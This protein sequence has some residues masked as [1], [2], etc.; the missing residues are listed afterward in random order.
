M[1][2]IILILIALIILVPMAFTAFWYL[3]ASNIKS[4]VRAQLNGIAVEMDTQGGTVTYSNIRTSG[5]PSSTN[6][7]ISDLSFQAGRQDD[8]VS[9]SVN[10]SGDLV[11]GASLFNKSE[12]NVA[13]PSLIRVETRIS[14]DVDTIELDTV[15]PIAVIH[16][17]DISI[18]NLLHNEATPMD[19]LQAFRSISYSDQGSTS[20]SQSS[21]GVIT[22]YSQNGSRI[23][24][25]INELDAMKTFDVVIEALGS[26]FET[27]MPQGAETTL[28]ENQK[29]F[30][31]LYSKLGSLDVTVDLNGSISKQSGASEKREFQLNIN[32]ISFNSDLFTA[33]VEGNLQKTLDDFLPHGRLKFSF[34][35]VNA[36]VD[37]YV[38]AFAIALEEYTST[39][40]ANENTL[41]DSLKGHEKDLHTNI[42]TLLRSIA[43]EQKKSSP[44]ITITLQRA[45]LGQN[46]MIGSLDL[47]DFA[48]RLILLFPTQE[49]VK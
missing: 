10:T 47:N 20:K 13:L 33:G 9:F 22:N 38:K 16:L 44:N 18:S 28:T 23:D 8:D 5:F 30:I 6:V 46:I 42:V 45:K 48:E 11:I 34:R 7:I 15:E 49:T 1:R 27:M 26:R 17:A 2:R 14:D 40:D 4:S 35:K 39:L 29:H 37:F 24:I 19:V 36:F 31:E 43:D 3:Q 12:L 21:S 41:L 32:D 25:S